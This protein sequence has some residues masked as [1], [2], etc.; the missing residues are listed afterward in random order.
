M[1]EGPPDWNPPPILNKAWIEYVDSLYPSP[2]ERAAMVHASI[3]PG[4]TQFDLLCFAIEYTSGTAVGLFSDTELL[5][6]MKIAARWLYATHYFGAPEIYG[7]P[8]LKRDSKERDGDTSGILPITRGDQSPL[9]SPK[10]GRSGAGEGASVR[11]SDV[12]R[13]TE[14]S[15][16]APGGDVRSSVQPGLR[17]HSEVETDAQ[18]ETLVGDSSDDSAKVSPRYGE[19]TEA[20]SLMG[21]DGKHTDPA[22]L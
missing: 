21:D 10:T 15:V 2:S 14:T 13:G 20:D 18:R 5:G 16:S 19:N 7:P 22:D 1:V 4:I 8:D 12:G 6:A 3:D 11:G 9:R 17:A